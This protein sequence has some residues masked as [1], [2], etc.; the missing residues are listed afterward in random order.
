M[1]LRQAEARDAAEISA[2]W[3]PMIRDTI[4][5]FSTEE[6]TAADVAA[7]IEQRGAAFIV[8]ELD[9]QVVGFATFGTFRNG[10]GYRHSAELTIILS[11]QARGKGVGRSL[12]AALEEAAR[13]QGIHVLVSGVSAENSGAVAFHNACGFVETG[14]MPE[15][16]R[17]FGRWHDL[18]LMQ[19]TV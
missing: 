16:G 6:K 14:R 2:F 13:G 7:M 4:I 19:K 11:D 9:G 17:K 12:I 3:A 8:A 10:P 18:V 15:V 5:T 1:I